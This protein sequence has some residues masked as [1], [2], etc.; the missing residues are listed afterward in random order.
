MD[1][2]NDKM[3]S[4]VEASIYSQKEQEISSALEAEYQI[5]FQLTPEQQREM[6]EIYEEIENG[7]T[8]LMFENAKSQSKNKIEEKKE[9]L[10]C[11]IDDVDDFLT[12]HPEYV[13]FNPT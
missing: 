11:K 5:H 10:A 13:G 3:F 12:Q 8:Q 9:P 6:N 1:D 2:K 4:T 7:S